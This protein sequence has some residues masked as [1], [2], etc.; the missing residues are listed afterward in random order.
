M[1]EFNVS[2]QNA[3]FVGDGETDVQTAI[4]CGIKGI[5]VLWGYR[6]K[7][8]LEKEGATVF[9]NNPKDLLSIIS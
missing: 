8:Q 6:T 2:P 9:V 5:S 1:Q 7:D 3:Y 4:N